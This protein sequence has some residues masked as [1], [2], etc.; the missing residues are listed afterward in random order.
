MAAAFI[1]LFVTPVF[2]LYMEQLRESVARGRAER[3]QRRRDRE[4]LEPILAEAD[5]QPAPAE[6]NA[7]AGHPLPQGGEGCF[8]PGRHGEAVL[9]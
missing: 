5:A 8:N 2:F 4:A 6:E 3:A 1:T 9:F 7:R